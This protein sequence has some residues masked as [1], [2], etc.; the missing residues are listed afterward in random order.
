[1]S[2]RKSTPR[3]SAPEHPFFG[4]WETPHHERAVHIVIQAL[5][6]T[7][8]NV[9]TLSIDADR[10][11]PGCGLHEKRAMLVSH[12]H[13]ALLPS[14]EQVFSRLK[15]LHLHLVGTAAE[16]DHSMMRR[17]CSLTRALSSLRAVEDL[18]LRVCC[19]DCPDLTERQEDATTILGGFQCDLKML[20]ILETTLTALKR[21]ALWSL[22]CHTSEFCDYLARHAATLEHLDIYDMRLLDG[23]TYVCFQKET[24]P[25]DPVEEP[26]LWAR[27]AH[28]CQSLPR[29][30]S[31][32]LR[33]AMEYRDVETP[34]GYVYRLHGAQVWEVTQLA[35]TGRQ[36]PLER[37]S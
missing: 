8:N 2:H 25:E 3:S 11:D 35:L 19:T 14:A 16:L 28:A 22:Y 34:M 12:L 10:E 18:S 15:S 4:L 26:H 13:K 30:E 24:T 20:L 7:P 32:V 9:T 6:R 23:E 17:G 5:A 21:L 37:A 29:L 27:L 36:M 31:F 1:M 33:D